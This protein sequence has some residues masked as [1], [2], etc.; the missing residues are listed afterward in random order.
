[1]LCRL[2]V[3]IASQH[4]ATEL[5]ANHMAT[6]LATNLQRE[7]MLI[8]YLAEPKLAMAAATRKWSSTQFFEKLLPSLQHALITG[9][10]TAGNRGELVAQIILLC[11]FDSAS[12]TIPGQFVLLRLVL[13]QL[14]PEHYT[15]V[16]LDR[17]I[18][19]SLE[20]SQIACAQIVRLTHL[21]SSFTP[22]E[23]AERHC[24]AA[25]TDLHP[26]V[27]LIFPIISSTL[28]LF[29]VQIKN[30]HHQM[31]ACA[32][33]FG[34]CRKMMPSYAFIGGKFNVEDLL[35]LDQNCVRLYFQLGASEPSVTA[36][37]SEGRHYRRRATGTGKSSLALRRRPRRSMR[38]FKLSR[39]S[40]QYE[41][42]SRSSLKAIKADKPIEHAVPLQ[43]FGLES[44]CLNPQVGSRFPPGL[45]G[46]EGGYE[47][48]CQPPISL[49]W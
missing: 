30:H 33:S 42:A 47:F 7:S 5:V 15:D 40:N 13:E 32:A 37:A 34:A 35:R 38:C 21:C 20:N 46:H 25:M 48:I 28:A 17:A 16:D 10:V 14:L 26:G 8:A 39:R 41:T 36:D 31:K 2:G 23:L 1:M 18:P 27:D 43:I 44:R 4:Y 45:V 29:L 24:G 6:L 22:V 49:L 11:A 12:G 19:K 3:S 9:A